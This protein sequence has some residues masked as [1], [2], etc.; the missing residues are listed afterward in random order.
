MAVVEASACGTP[1]VVVAGE[2]NAATELIDEGVNG[3]V[4]DQPDADSIA[5]AIVRVH[6]AGFDLRDSTAEWFSANAHRLSLE[7]SLTSVLAAYGGDAEQG[8]GARAACCA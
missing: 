3:F 4:V 1:S 6:K 8:D 5:D 7:S 2:N